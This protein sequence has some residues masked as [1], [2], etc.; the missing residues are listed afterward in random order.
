MP[1]TSSFNLNEA[2]AQIFESRFLTVDTS[3]VGNSVNIV[4]VIH[5]GSNSDKLKHL[6]INARLKDESKLNNENQKTLSIEIDQTQDQQDIVFTNRIENLP[7]GDYILNVKALKEISDEPET[8]LNVTKGFTINNTE[9]SGTVSQSNEDLTGRST[10]QSINQGTKW[11]C[12]FPGNIK[13]CVAEILYS[14]V[15]QPLAWLT[16]WA[17][18]FLDFFIY[19]STNSSSYSFSFVGKAWGA[20]R[21]IANIFFIIALLYVAIQTIL[22]MGH[23]TKKIIASIIVIGL[24]INFS[25]F[26]SQVVIDSSNILAKVFYNGITTKDNTG[27]VV[28]GAEGEKNISVALMELVNPQN[29]VGGYDDANG[30]L[31]ILITLFASALMIFM[32]YIFLSVAFLFVGRV[33]GL[34]L[35]MIFAPIAFASYTLPFDFGKIGHQKWWSELFKQAFM[36]PIFIFFLYIILLMGDALKTVSTVFD[37]Q[38]DFLNVSMSTIVPFALIFILLHQAKKLATEYAGEVG[39]GVNKIGA[40]VS[41]AAVGIASG[42]VA[43]A[44]TATLGRFSSKIS[45]SRTLQNLEARGVPLFSGIASGIRRLGESGS[46]A[47]FDL[48]N[49]KIAGQGLATVGLTNLGKTKNDGFEG[50]RE[51]QINARLKRAESLKEKS[52]KPLNQAVKKAETAV[53]AKEEELKEDLEILDAKM[54]AK[55]EYRT[56]LNERLKNITDPVKK[57]AMEKEKEA[58]DIELLTLK[59]DKETISAPLTAAKDALKEAKKELRHRDHEIIETYAKTVE[60]GWNKAGALITGKTIS[61]TN[62]SAYR[63]RMNIKPKGDSGGGHGGDNHGHGGGGHAKPKPAPKPASAPAGGGVH[64]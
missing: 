46:K 47:T 4:S 21:D 52:T 64:H 48:R 62:E 58:L 2:N 49:A 20:V 53:H 55:R 26:V 60:S 45:E 37:T 25:L 54:K 9:S 17:A 36:A 3:I 7:Q 6:I 40:M 34:W 12:D 18:K 41:G 16:E 23:G 33:A 43:L 1:L 14:L 44:G 13:G 61:G 42:G 5:K 15:F 50:A 59:Q 32:I 24:V 27:K 39:A 8:L 63:M 57:A 31:F 28:T 38:S 11:N 56:D 10:Q 30:G 35:S 29:I 51:R 19:Y 22:G